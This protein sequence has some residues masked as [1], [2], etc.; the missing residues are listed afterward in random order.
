MSLAWV[1][2]NRLNSVQKLIMMQFLIDDVY[3]KRVLRIQK[4]HQARLLKAVTLI[5]RLIFTTILPGGIDS[6]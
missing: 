3:S 5:K 4:T 2:H 1:E 6:H